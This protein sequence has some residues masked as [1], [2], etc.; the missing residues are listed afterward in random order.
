MIIPHPTIPGKHLDT[1][2]GCFP[3]SEWTG[4]CQR[5]FVRNERFGPND[6]VIPPTAHKHDL[7]A[8]NNPASSKR[9]EKPKQNAEDQESLFNA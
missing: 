5:G 3:I 8:L 7:K 2:T 1:E 4:E 9:W 6:R